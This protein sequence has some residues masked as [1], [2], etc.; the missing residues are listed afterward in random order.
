MR[1]TIARS[2][3]ARGPRLQDPGRPMGFA[4]AN[5]RVP[6]SVRFDRMDHLAQ[7]S[8]TQVKCADCGMKTKHL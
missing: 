7:P 6:N 1:R 4:T 2:L 8:A 5:S 3:M